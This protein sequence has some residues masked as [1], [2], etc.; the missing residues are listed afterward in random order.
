MFVG[1]L[2][3]GP[4]EGTGRAEKLGDAEGPQKEAGSAR[5]HR[6]GSWDE[7]GRAGG[8]GRV[9]SRWAREGTWKVVQTQEGEGEAWWMPRRTLGGNR[10]G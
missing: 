3:G 9:H 5:G 8:L 7:A 4:Q 2:Q 1:T 10:E 6:E